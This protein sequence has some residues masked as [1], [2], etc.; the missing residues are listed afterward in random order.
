MST[1][2]PFDEGPGCPSS[3]ALRTA[4]TLTPGRDAVINETDVVVT[5]LRQVIITLFRIIQA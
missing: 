2:S 5:P 4:V 3:P 1:S